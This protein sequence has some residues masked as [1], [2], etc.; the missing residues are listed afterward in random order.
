MSGGRAL[1]TQDE[2]AALTGADSTLDREE[3]CEAV[4]NR[5]NTFERDL[6]VLAAHEPHLF[7]QLRTAI[8]NT[9]V[10]RTDSETTMPDGDVAQTLGEL[11]VPVK[12]EK[13][14][15]AVYA[16]RDFVR[17]NDEVSKAE[18]IETIMPIYPLT[19]DVSDA[20]RPDEVNGESIEW[21][22]EIIEPGL[23]R[24][25]DVEPVTDSHDVWQSIE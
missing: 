25:P 15:A 9:P 19:Y 20:H 17:A 13:S 18:I 22:E 7:E 3:V 21:F 8:E 11:D 14:K 10:D 1:L 12:S 2:R 5:L 6:H 16:A 23:Q 4:Q 24:L